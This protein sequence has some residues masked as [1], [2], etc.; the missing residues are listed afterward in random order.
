ME[1]IPVLDIM[2]GI[3]VCGRGGDRK[4]Y[5]PLKT[6]LCNSSDPLEVARRYRREG[7]EK[8]YI[9]DLDAITKKGN[10]FC[11][12]KSIEGYKILDGGITSKLELENLRSLNICD[13]VVVGT[14]T[15]RDLDLLNED[16]ILSLDFKNGELLSPINY[17]LEEIL[18][19][20]NSSIPLIILDISSV[21]TQRGINWNL[22]EEVMKKV[23]NPIYVGGG[24]RDEKD[25]K[26]C[27]DMGIQGVLIG[28]GIHRGTL[29]LREIIERYRD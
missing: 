24:V 5:R 19:R 14:E 1:I 21:G 10:N 6:V 3:A 2:S 22:V 9:A 12:I 17:T 11:I 16:I 25:L 7:A 18:D 4:N 26:R 20:L 8:I 28:T 15:L 27:Y 29:N 13:K 23:E